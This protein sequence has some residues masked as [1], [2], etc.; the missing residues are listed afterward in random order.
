[1]ALDAQHLELDLRNCVHEF[2][3][4]RGKAGW[5]I[6]ERTAF[7]LDHDA[8]LLITFG[9]GSGI[10]QLSGS[11]DP[12][13]VRSVVGIGVLGSAELS[14]TVLV[15]L[16]RGIVV[17]PLD[18][19]VVGFRGFVVIRG[20]H[21]FA[22]QLLVE[23]LVRPELCE[24]ILG[25]VDP[26]RCLV[27]LDVVCE[28]G[29]PDPVDPDHVCV[30]L[31]RDCPTIEHALHGVVL[32]KGFCVVLVL[33]VVLDLLV[34]RLPVEPACLPELGESPVERIPLGLVEG[35]NGGSDPGAAQAQGGSVGHEF[36]EE[37]HDWVVQRTLFAI[38]LAVRDE[39]ALVVVPVLHVHIRV[40]VI[41]F[42]V[43]QS[44]R[45]QAG[46]ILRPT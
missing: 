15:A 9:L 37:L 2:L 17:R 11:L 36:F 12:L 6:V 31:G 10:F 22:E 8:L 40:G 16:E 42:R 25:V 7:G 18:R 19:E 46:Q 32:R 1:M 21:D 45:D 41:G 35:S 3:D 33:F 28:H 4:L 29:Q 30:S 13:Q 20:C 24:I 27:S 34:E 43:V 5:E 23:L 26:E 14:V 44:R 39:L 38:E